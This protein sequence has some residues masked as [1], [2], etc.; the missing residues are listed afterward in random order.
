MTLKNRGRKKRLR[1]GQCRKAGVVVWQWVPT[2][3]EAV[4][5]PSGISTL[6]HLLEP[7]ADPMGR[8]WFGRLVNTPLGTVR[9]PIGAALLVPGVYVV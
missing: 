9:S 2:F 3:K 7:S 8:G 1:G 5:P 6:P 4:P